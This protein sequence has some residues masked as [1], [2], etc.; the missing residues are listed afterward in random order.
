MLACGGEIDAIEPELA[1]APQLR[2]T[3]LNGCS[4]RRFPRSLPSGSFVVVSAFKAIQL[5]DL[6]PADPLV[7]G[8]PYA[9]FGLVFAGA[10]P[11][12][13]LTR[14]IRACYAVPCSFASE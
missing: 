7:S 2:S 1:P 10:A 6:R 14:L 9:P 13:V 11:D 4:R 5:A 8:N 12:L 3:L